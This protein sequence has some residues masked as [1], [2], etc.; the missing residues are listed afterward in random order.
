MDALLAESL[1]VARATGT[2][3]TSDLARV[4]V[5][6]TVQPKD[7]THPTDAKPMLRRSTSSARKP[8]P[9]G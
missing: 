2:L 9:M 8:N 6:T 3:K 7:V 1:R 5:D 4:T